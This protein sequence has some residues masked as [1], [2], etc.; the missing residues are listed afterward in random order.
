[1]TESF[2]FPPHPMPID[3]IYNNHKSE[4]AKPPARRD[5]GAYASESDIL[6]YSIGNLQYFLLRA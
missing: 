6:K 4:E 1:M 2:E 5:C 3:Y